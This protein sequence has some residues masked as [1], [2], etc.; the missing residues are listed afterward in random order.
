M[1]GPRRLAVRVDGNRHIGLGHFFRC[2]HLA[3]FLRGRSWE[4]VFFV[5]E[6]S[7]G[8]VV[9]TFLEEA[10]IPAVTVSRPGRPWEPDDDAFLRRVSEGRFDC[11]LTDLLQ[12]DSGDDDLLHNGEFI[13]ADVEGLLARLGDAGTPV[14]ALSDRFDPVRLR[15][16]AVVNTCPA[17]RP[18]WY[19]GSAVRHLL[20]PEYY[21]LPPSFREPAV[22]PRVFAPERPLVVVFCGGND[23]RGFTPILLEGLEPYRERLRVEVVL[24]AAT[25]DGDRVAAGYEAR[26]YPCRFKVRDMAPVLAGADFVVSAS[27]NTLFDLAALGTPSGAVST[28]E[29]QRVTARFFE[30]AGASLDFG[31]DAAEI[32]PRLDAAVR[33]VV[34]DRSQLEA[35]SR[36]GRAVVDGKGL[37][38]VSGELERLADGG[39][40]R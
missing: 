15:A 3:T 11:A 2:L 37:E 17:Q 36:A 5:L 35:M 28:R 24:G 23:H 1:G 18:E 22:R 39:G 4:V 14:M 27:G 25:P 19:A 40:R 38:R 6:S 26:G 30:Q 32:L 20:G 31:L 21:F 8:E 12:C 29:R 16:D 34:F 9:S 10:G 33:G 13:P 7:R